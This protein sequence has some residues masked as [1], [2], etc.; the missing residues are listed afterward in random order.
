MKATRNLI[1]GAILG[2]TCALPVASWA[3]DTNRASRVESAASATVQTDTAPDEA[4][5]RAIVQKADEIRLPRDPFQVE[6]SVAT[7][8]GG[9]D[10]DAR[11]YR[12]LSRGSD[13]TIVLTQEP[14]TERGQNLLMKGREL[15]LYMPS[16]S[17][18][19]RLSLSQ[20]L[21]GLV[22]NGDLARA[23]F[24]GDYTPRVV[25]TERLDGREHHIVELI[26]SERG[27]TYPKV[28]YWVRTGDFH[29]AKAEFYS[30]SG[31]LMK[32]C[33]Y[34]NYRTLGGRSRPTRLV[35]SDAL[36]PGDE[37]IL[38]YSEMKLVELPERMFTKDYLKKLD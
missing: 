26:A 30:L 15:W 10:L 3:Q 36:K 17:Q 33:R 18:P 29:P 9:Q 20:R 19:V 28:V 16:V 35:M 8:A 27:V 4:A 14:A 1:G 11:R 37:S 7:R 22:S 5:A 24:S 38:D 21:T 23:N 2:L 32:T 25:G 34:E 6:V 13:N 31:R 12:I